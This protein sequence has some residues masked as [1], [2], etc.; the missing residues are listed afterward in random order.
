MAG[1]VVNQKFLVCRDTKV[2]QAPAQVS[3]KFHD[4]KA[5]QTVV[6]LD[7]PRQLPDGSLCVPI[8]PRGWVDADVLRDFPGLST[9][10]VTTQVESSGEDAW[11]YARDAEPKV[12]Y[13]EA[14][15]K[16][17]DASAKYGGNKSNW[18]HNAKGQNDDPWGQYKQNDWDKN[19]W[20][21]NDWEDSQD[22]QDWS[23]DDSSSG[24]GQEGQAKWDQ[25]ESEGDGYNGYHGKTEHERGR[26][27]PCPEEACPEEACPEEET[28]PSS[29]IRG[30]PGLEPF[31]PV[32][33]AEDVEIVSSEGADE[34]QFC[35]ASFDGEDSPEMIRH[36]LGDYN[37]SGSHH[38]CKTFQR[39]LGASYSLSL[40][41]FDDSL[42]PENQGWY[43]GPEVAGDEVYAWSPETTTAPPT[44]SWHIPID[45]E[46]AFQGFKVLL[47]GSVEQGEL[48]EEA[49]LQAEWKD[50][51]Q[52]E[53]WDPPPW[54]VSRHDPL[55]KADPWAKA[56]GNED[57]LAKADPWSAKASRSQ[58]PLAKADPW[59]K[60]SGNEDPLA[61]ADPWAGKASRNEDPLAKADPWAKEP[62]PK[63]A[64]GPWQK[65]IQNQLHQGSSYTNGSSG[66]ADAKAKA[67]KERDP[68]EAEGDPW[69]SKAQNDVGLNGH[70]NGKNDVGLNGHANGKD[71]VGLNGHANGKAAYKSKALDADAPPFHPPVRPPGISGGLD[72]TWSQ[73]QMT[74]EASAA[75]DA[76]MADHLLRSQWRHEHSDAAYR[77]LGDLKAILR[78]QDHQGEVKI[79]GSCA[80]SFRSAKS[81]LDVTYTGDVEN[82]RVMSTL[83]TVMQSLKD[84][85]YENVTKVF[86][87]QT[88]LVKFTD[89]SSNMEVDFCLQ[90]DLGIRN[91]KMLECYCRCDYRVQMLGRLVKD[92]AKRFDIVSSTDGCLNSYAYM[93]MVLYYL[94]SLQPE[95][96]PNLQQ[97]AS[98]EGP[99]QI[100]GRDG[101]CETKFFEQVDDLPR[102]ENKSSV[103][104][105]LYGFFRFYSEEFD[106]SQNAVCI[107]EGRPAA[108][109]DKF[110]LST[111]TYYEQ[112]YIEDPFDLQ[113]NLGGKCSQQGKD[114]IIRQMQCAKD[115]LSKA[116][117]DLA[118]VCGPPPER[119]S[120]FLR[121]RCDKD[122]TPEELLDAFRDLDLVRLH[123]P[124]GGH[125]RQA[126]LEFASAAARRRAHAKNEGYAGSSQLML[127]PS[128]EIGVNTAKQES[129]YTVY[130]AQVNGKM[131]WQ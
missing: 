127:I 80:T 69:K 29:V 50:E 52:N 112:W 117:P 35:T 125:A 57:P 15:A 94:Q 61:K 9:S 77:I 56:S 64:Q 4:L 31:E 37:E 46:Q 16:A 75:L 100:Q 115:E 118:K 129:T 58:D 102:S 82:G 54:E 96:I 119:N 104:D 107:R 81:D 30:A 33:K 59:A 91:S 3:T 92:W 55:A 68:L 14:R 25:E 41:Y 51:G 84:R 6:V 12:A 70:T 47:R 26:L 124:T 116:I 87:T 19:A 72:Q 88:R 49:K 73:A 109:V 60:A 5:G 103:A 123:F 13:N 130:E 23:K 95:V 11:Q 79:F 89:P 39:F 7:Q 131:T 74:S 106:W 108:V 83:A 66:N 111:K 17:G 101:W 67:G 99:C 36:L 27:E 110:G 120:F 63:L 20:A 10:E 45:A 98:A 40:Y 48:E 126:F 62:N 1:G 65:V 43:I 97:M 22:K 122:M 53:Q 44:S 2:R 86:T 105:L 34:V 18:D 76:R 113:H 121:C 85:G 114:Y 21:K 42:G 28:E 38:G 71:D 32:R 93:L 128:H 78:E 24:W 8:Q 90:N